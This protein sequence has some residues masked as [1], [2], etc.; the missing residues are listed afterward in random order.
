MA[1]SPLKPRAKLKRTLTRGN[2]LRTTGDA[3]ASL[4]VL[5]A[6]LV[7]PK[8]SAARREASAAAPLRFSSATSLA[9]PAVS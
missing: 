9:P 4:P 1:T 3:L 7:R 2:F 5:L 6:A 8:T